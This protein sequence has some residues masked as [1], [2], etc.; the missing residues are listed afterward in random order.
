MSGNPP[1]QMTL[2]VGDVL[3]PYEILA[4]LGAGGMGEVFR[5]R[6]PRLGRE[7]ALKV[8]PRPV[9][10]DA[11]RLRR[12]EQEARAAGQ[13]D[14]PNLLT[15]FDV[16]THAGAP[17]IVS[18][19]LRGE[20]LRERLA[21]GPLPRAKAVEI[22]VQ[23]AGGLAA[24]HE[25]G[26]VHRDLKPEN[27]FL[28]RDGRA[29]I[30]DFGLARVAA[31]VPAE[32]PG[33][34]AGTL[35]ALT[36]PGTVVG[37]AGYMSPEQVRGEP[38][39][40]RSDL[41]SFG[42]VLYEMLASRRAFGG[43]TNIETMHAILTQEP[44]LEA[45]APEIAN[46]P[47]ARVLRR[48]LEKRR[49][50][51]FRSA[52]D[53]AF[54]LE[55]S[56]GSRPSG[57][58][59]VSVASRAAVVE[60]ATG[61]ARLPGWLLASG[62]ALIALAGGWAIGRRTATAAARLAPTIADATLTPLT[63]DPGDEIDPSFA[64]D[65]ETIAYASD[66]SGNYEIYL[67][68][69]SGGPA[70]NLTKDGADDV[71]PAFSPDGRW[72][73]FV[74][75]R[76]SRHPLTYRAPRLPLMG[77]D[78][79]VMSAFG[80]PTHRIAEDGNFPAWSPDGKYV[81]YI[82]GPWFRCE[83]RR[84][85]ATGGRAETIPVRL[86]RRAPFVLSP[87]L[88]PDGRWLAFWTPGPQAVY[89]VPAGGGDARL[90]ASGHSP[91]FT[92]DGA[93]IVYTNAEPGK[94]YSVWRLPFDGA[95]GMPSGPGA[96]LTFGTSENATVALSRDGTKVALAAVDRAVNLEALPFD[97]D[98]AG[99]RGA[100]VMLTRGSRRVR[101]FGPSPDG[102]SVAFVDERGG[103]GSLWRVDQDG[104]EPF[105]LTSD[106]GF[107]DSFPRWSPDARAI[108]FSRLPRRPAGGEQ[109]SGDLWVMSADGANPHSASLPL[110]A[111]S[112][113]LDATTLIA[114]RASPLGYAR[115][116]LASGKVTPVLQNVNAM[117]IFDVSQDGR[118]LAGQSNE[119]DTVDV[120]AVPVDGSETPRYVVTA[121]TDDYHP[122]FSPS[123]RWL[124]YQAEHKNIFRVPGPA[125]GWR[126]APAEQVTHFPERGIYLEEP[127][128]SR[129]GRTLFYARAQISGDI[130]LLRLGR[131]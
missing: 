116:D 13:L 26:I 118:W 89:V 37:T 10:G 121:P 117:P 71:Q 12:F 17:F 6:D 128:I 107:D 64:P 14:H 2:A 72:I 50:D 27:I 54:A 59:A 49:E 31:E 70:I 85:A 82:T 43:A 69:I 61:R 9:A 129:D 86:S 53:L 126:A 19:L 8:L 99:V 92:A 74:S 5:A 131:H 111:R 38:V 79:W 90:V 93:A 106:P 24:A 46:D 1:G 52:E 56:R 109:R 123:G 104:P 75:T 110:G 120:L 51:R 96:P 125:Q 95:R 105:Q 57:A 39:D 114:F 76:Q 7:V 68:R 81:Y 73:A 84:V 100:P 122:F 97:A 22:A 77:G 60:A 47:L 98:G 58:S 87:T 30:L 33:S 66:R 88:S 83:I 11:D 25:K 94:N 35:P 112:V 28:T 23:V 48:C 113:W 127:Q 44:S 32:P 45:L 21:S 20:T 130:W 16:G 15:V 102:R 62:I 80:G 119:H 103:T 36:S 91:V 55:L 3:G 124:Y 41:F 78:V 18:E 101:F 115:L 108:S 40:A 42:A 65:D 63:V 34:E 67:Q 4:P 29:K